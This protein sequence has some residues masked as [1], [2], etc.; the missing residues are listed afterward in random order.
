[1]SELKKVKTTVL[2][3]PENHKLS[4][5]ISGFDHTT[6]VYYVELNIEWC[7]YKE[8]VDALQARIDELMTKVAELQAE[9]DHWK[10]KYINKLQEWKP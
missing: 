8:Q 5:E 3:Q 6:G 7:R 4:L 2:Q 10:L 1:M 9:S